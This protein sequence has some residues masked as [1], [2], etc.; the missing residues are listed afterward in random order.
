VLAHAGAEVAELPVESHVAA[1]VSGHD[2]RVAR[3]GDLPAGG[4]VVHAAADALSAVADALRGAGAR[5]VGRATL[6]VLRIEEGRAWYGIDVAEENLLHE[7]GLLQE[8][9]SF[10]KGCYI[11]QEVVARLEGRG[12]HVNKRLMGLQL[13]SAAPAGSAVTAEGKDVGRVTTAGVSP[14]LGPIALAYVHRSVD[15]GA[16]V[17]IGGAPARVAQLPLAERSA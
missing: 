5:D 10:T 12:A 6:D 15:P 11:G 7:T 14:R 9:H 1:A 16:T 4:F 17:T 3:A 13:G 8:Y 2:V